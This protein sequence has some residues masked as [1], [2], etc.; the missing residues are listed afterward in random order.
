MPSATNAIVAKPDA[1]MLKRAEASNARLCERVSLI[2]AVA[3]SGQSA[4]QLCHFRWIRVLRL[5]SIQIRPARPCN[6]RTPG[7]DC[8]SQSSIRAKPPAGGTYVAHFRL[9]RQQ[10][11]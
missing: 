1:R 6:A 8:L 10:T 3:G 11:G 9:T 4:S 2:R 7:A 5:I